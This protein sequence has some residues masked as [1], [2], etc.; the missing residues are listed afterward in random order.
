M[1]GRALTTGLV[2]TVGILLVIAG[3]AL[4]LDP[5]LVA[6]V[7]GGLAMIV[8][9]LARGRRRPAPIRTEALV[10]AAAMIT[11]AFL[12]LD[13]IAD[14]TLLLALGFLVLMIGSWN[15]DRAESGYSAASSHQ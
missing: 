12:F 15:F 6:I 10:V 1:N 4:L 5:V 11:T 3:L 8:A 9:V 14:G 2:T 13:G 7:I